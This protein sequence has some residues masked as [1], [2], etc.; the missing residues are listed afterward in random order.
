MNLPF[1]DYYPILEAED[2]LLG[3]QA[4]VLTT[5]PGFSGSGFAGDFSQVGDSVTFTVDLEIAGD[6]YTT[7]QYANG[8]N[9]DRNLNI[10]VNGV[11]LNQTS[12]DPTGA[13]DI[14]Q[15]QT[16][17]LNLQ[18]GINT[19]EYRYD[20]NN[21]GNLNLDY[22]WLTKNSNNGVVGRPIVDSGLV[23]EV[24]KFVQLPDDSVGRSRQIAMTTQGT[25][26]YVIEERDGKIYQIADGNNTSNPTPQLFFDV[27]QAIPLNTAGRNLNTANIVHGGLKGI[28]FHPEFATNGKFYTSIM[29]DRPNDPSNFNYLSDSSNPIP[30]DSVLVEWTYNFQTD[31]VDPNSYRE[32][33][34]V[35]MP[36]Y[37]HP[38]KEIS[39]NPFAVPGDEDY[40]LLYIAHGDGSVQS[41]TAGGGLNADALGKMLRINPLQSGTSPYTIPSNNP[42]VG[43][44]NMLDEVY[45]IGHRNP[46]TF[47]FAQDSQGTTHIL[48]AEPGRD[49]IEEVNLIVPG[50]NYGWSA[51]EGTFVHQNDSQG[52]I[53][54]LSP[55]P[56]D[57]ADNGYIYPA[58]QWGHVQ[59]P[60]GTFVGQA[61]AGGYVIDNG[62]ELAG[63]YFFADFA[64]FGR[65][66]HSNFDDLLN[67]VTQLDPNDPSRD[68]PS[69]LTQA[70][71]GEV[72]LLF[73]HDNDPNTPSLPRDSFLDILDDEASYDNSGRADLRFG[74]GGSGELYVLN[75]RNGY[76]YLVTSSVGKAVIRGT[77]GND[78]LE[79]SVQDE[80][81]NGFQGNDVLRGQAGADELNGASGRDTLEGGA[82]NDTLNGDGWS[83]SLMG[84]SGNDQLNGGQGNDTLKGGTGNDLLNGGN[85]NDSLSG[86][87]GRDTLNGG[88]G[89]DTL[90]GGG[91]SDSLMGNSGSDRLNGGQGND[92]L[93]GGFGK[94]TLNGGNGLDV[95]VLTT[96]TGTDT[97]QD[98]VQGTDRIG[99][100]DGLAFADLTFDANNIL[101]NGETVATLNISASGLTES[102]FTPV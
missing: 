47:S 36:V 12:F 24:Q 102:D 54:G 81:I 73:D 62:S 14:W 72:T 2:A 38:I 70:E 15:A 41:A 22:L 26:L 50:G 51:R 59:D 101:V 89:K 58:A 74:R 5:Y 25:D 84:N 71:I 98:F 80:I 29:E 10:Y 65:I 66:Y 42:F 100:A 37:D 92:T 90:N 16:E 99:L 56:E 13:W 11:A 69:E 48:V 85:D 64:R 76:V 94:D 82:G 4:S 39:F 96:G 1:I 23:F 97:I 8:S 20:N 34:R 91:W 83:D 6:Y 3:G 44:P 31:A 9:S 21:T 45:S 18:A 52:V 79:G 7:L 93:S 49:N 17:L 67:S 27:K 88:N 61:I 75:K 78:T 33:F 40:G 32:I 43:D 86:S 57:D 95:F 53:E 68:E 60:G 87:T 35:G 19:I 55:L 28:A 77:S 30:A 46:H 63:E